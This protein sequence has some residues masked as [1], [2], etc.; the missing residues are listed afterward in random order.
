MALNYSIREIR[1]LSEVL[2][3]ETEM[4]FNQMSQSFLKRR[5][6]LFGEKKGVKKNE[7]ILA[8]LKDNAFKDDLINNIVVP[9]TE[10]FRDPGL[11]RKIREYFLF[12]SDQPN[13]KV[14]IPQ[15]ASGEELYTLLIVA[16]ETGV[17]DKIEVTAGYCASVAKERVEQGVIY[18]KKMDTN[19]YNYKRYEG[20]QSLEGYMEDDE[21][22][23]KLKSSF[24]SKIHFNKGCV[25]VVKPDEKVDLVLFRNVMLYYKKD[26][27]SVLKEAIDSSLKPGGWLC[28]G[29]KEQF[30][31]PYSDRFECIDQKEKVF[32]KFN[33]LTQ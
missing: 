20:K 17:L 23:L 33:A 21:D 6:Y 25:T 4:P 10:L 8:G 19:L 7:Q 28:I 3:Q 24:L 5:L 22:T 11:W 16:E 31:S 26:Y 13:I 9:V 14:W 29:V 12:L 1:E 32:L 27:H 18:S 2:T 30:P 15:I